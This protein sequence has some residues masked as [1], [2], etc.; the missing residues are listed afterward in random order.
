MKTILTGIL[1]MGCLLGAA[2][3][4]TCPEPADRSDERS[5]LLGILKSAPDP[6]SGQQA[7]N[8]V[9][10]F[11][12]QAPDGKAQ[13]LLNRGMALIRASQYPTAERV[14]DQLVHYCP[15]FA[16]GWNQRAFA[17]FLNDRYDESLADIETVLRLEP[18]HFG[19]LSGRAQILIR[20]GRTGLAQLAIQDALKVHPWIS[21]R[22][23][24]PDPGQDI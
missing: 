8:D 6:F 7:A 2:R 23:A 15:A 19:A 17:R 22:R 5:K 3:A 20:Q 1:V 9:W 12:V 11:W 4:E 14:L 10:A 21:D 16:E 18:A 13:E 24:L